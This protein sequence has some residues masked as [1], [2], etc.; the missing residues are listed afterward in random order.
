MAGSGVETDF[1]FISSSVR[2]TA[3]SGNKVETQACIDPHIPK[4]LVNAYDTPEKW[5]ES[6][7]SKQDKPQGRFGGS[8]SKPSKEAA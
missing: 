7:H 6:W 3:T 1:R 4:G 2:Q 5:E 8:T